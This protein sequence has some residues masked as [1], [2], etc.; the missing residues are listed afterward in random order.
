M[1]GAHWRCESGGRRNWA[2]TRTQTGQTHRPL[3]GEDLDGVASLLE[4]ET[5]LR[6]VKQFQIS[7]REERTERDIWQEGFL[8]WITMEY[9]SPNQSMPNNLEYSYFTMADMANNTEC[10]C[11]Q[12]HASSQSGPANL[13][14]AYALMRLC[15]W[16]KEPGRPPRP[17]KALKEHS[18]LHYS[19]I[20]QTL[21]CCLL[22]CTSRPLNNPMA[23]K[24]PKST[25]YLLL[26]NSSR[27][28]LTLLCLTLFNSSRLYL[29]LPNYICLCSTLPDSRGK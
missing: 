23:P 11:M 16:F 8:Q 22:N 20:P 10:I 24:G 9:M 26:L 18:T 25:F 2:Q 7:I 5:G 27:F 3:E 1:R 29:T 12:M 13:E 4:G 14:M 15:V 19:T 6:H 17:P 21:Q 28:Y